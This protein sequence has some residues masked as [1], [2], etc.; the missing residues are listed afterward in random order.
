KQAW[1]QAVENFHREAGGGA[2]GAPPRV[3][4]M[5]RELISAS[6]ALGNLDDEIR[7][8]TRDLSKER[9]EEQVCRRR[10]SLAREVDDMETV[11]IAVEFAERHA[12]RAA[13]LERKITVLQDERA[14]LARDVAAMR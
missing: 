13:V 12:E 4:A 10:E 1:R 8:T 6:G 14:L 5:E 9:E 2:T 3:R 11:R 7:R